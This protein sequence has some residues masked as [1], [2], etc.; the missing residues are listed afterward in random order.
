VTRLP[1]GTFGGQSNVVLSNGQV[2]PLNNPGFSSVS[3][4]FNFAKVKTSGVDFELHYARKFGDVGLNSRFIGS[5]LINHDQFVFPANPKQSGRIKSS[6]GTPDWRF[7]LSNSLDLGAVNFTHRLQYNSKQIVLASSFV[8]GLAGF[9]QV[10]FPDKGN[11]PFNPDATPFPYYPAH[12]THDFRLEVEA[13][14]GFQFFAGVDNAFDALPPYDILGTEGGAL[15]DPT[16]RFFYAG[17]K[18]KF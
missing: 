4:S 8:G 2:V 13:A 1:N 9:Y 10:F 18:V 6:F 7:Q 15:Y 12:F 11:A 5:Y 3:S 14:P 16:G 17:A